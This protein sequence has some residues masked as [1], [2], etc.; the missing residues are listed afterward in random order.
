MKDDLRPSRFLFSLEKQSPTRFA[1]MLGRA[2]KYANAEEAMLTKRST[3]SNQPKRKEKEKWEEPSNG[4]HPNQVRGSIRPPSPKFYNY[5]PLNTPR[6]QIL[7]EVKDQLPL[8][9][10][11][12][13]LSN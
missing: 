13:T 12:I 10:R 11:M 7:M 9:R 3:A 2:E 4:D 1:K 8:P 5:A 6:S